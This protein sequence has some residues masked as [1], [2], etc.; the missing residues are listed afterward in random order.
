MNDES[1]IARTRRGLSRLRERLFGQHIT[2]Y[3][4]YAYRDP[5]D[6]GE[7]RVPLRVWVYDDRDTPGVGE[8]IERLAEAHFERDLERPL[9][10]DEAARLEER[11][12]CFIADDK[13]GEKVEFT[14]GDAEPTFRLAARTTPNGIIEETI[15]IPNESVSGGMEGNRW[16]TI[17][18]RTADGHGVGEGRIQFLEPEGLSIVSDIDDTV[19]ITQVP[20]GKATVLRNIFLNPWRAAEG[21]C[22]RYD[23]LATEAK[24]AHEDVSFH[25]VSGSPWQLYGLLCEFLLDEGRFPAGTFHMK[26]LRKNLFEAGAIES[27]RAFAVGGDLATLDQKIRQ[28]TQLMLHLPRRQFVLVGDSGEKDPEVYRAIQRLFPAQVRRILIRDVLGER[29]AGMERITGAD[30]PVALDTT[31]VEK[32]M[33]DLVAAA[34]A[35]AP[36]YLYP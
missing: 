30:V 21:M 2:V 20:A 15:R 24:E 28:I 32:E 25:Y 9:T 3:P 27:I 5:K 16:L 33:V 29:L 4:T 7:W 11:L 23:Q 17:H 35:E 13:S 6:A 8:A 14:L 10:S 1:L 36:P 31:A 19:K 22:V 18:A 34:N 12:A 26:N